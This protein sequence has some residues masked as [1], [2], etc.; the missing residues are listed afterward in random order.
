[1]LGAAMLLERQVTLYIKKYEYIDFLIQLGNGGENMV[2]YCQH[3][4]FDANVIEFKEA[5]F[6]RCN[7]WTDLPSLGGLEQ[8]SVFVL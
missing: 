5:C 1:M 3:D 7:C 8:I 4:T 2:G 6:A